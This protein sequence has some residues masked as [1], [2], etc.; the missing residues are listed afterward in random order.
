MIYFTSHI[1]INVGMNIGV[2][3]VTG[4]TLPFV[5]YGGSHLL[6]ECMALGILMSFRKQSRSVYKD[7]SPDVFLR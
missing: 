6:I 4:V 1:I 2:M 7:D 3:P 5:S